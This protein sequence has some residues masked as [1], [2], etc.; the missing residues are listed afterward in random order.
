M[1]PQEQKLLEEFLGQLVDVPRIQKD[2]KAAAL[3]GAAVERQPD[4]AYL[5]VQ[6][7]LLVQ[8][9]LEASQAEVARLQAEAREAPAR[10]AGAGFLDPNAWGR[11]ATA[12]P[13]AGA[14]AALGASRPGALAGAVPAT[15]RG[16]APA[17]RG[18]GGSF[19]G[20]AAAMAAGVAG[21]AFLFQGINHLLGHGAGATP[22]AGA[23]AGPQ[24]AETAAAEPPAN[25]Q[26]ADSGWADDAP[27][28]AGGFDMGGDFV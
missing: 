3:I 14:A 11:P 2:H 25:D 5:L 1:S 24:P 9:A 18:A 6:R 16:A 21:G 8:Q 27:D 17:P 13:A 4:A 15:M 19:L 28:A 26:M 10:T 20:Q 23:Q 12:A 22:S 7:A